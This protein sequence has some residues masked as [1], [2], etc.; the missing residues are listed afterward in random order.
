MNSPCFPYKNARA[1]L[2]WDPEN[3]GVITRDGPDQSEI[4]F[5]SSGQERCYP[6]DQFEPAPPKENAKRT[7]TDNPNTA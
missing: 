4:K 3:P 5:D 7:R 2:K 6:N 1:R